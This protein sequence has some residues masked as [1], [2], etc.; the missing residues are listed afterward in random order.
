MRLVS[1]PKANASAGFHGG[2]PVKFV[3]LKLGEINPTSWSGQCSFIALAAILACVFQF[4]TYCDIV[5]FGGRA[6][7]GGPI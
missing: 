7:L 1:R 3:Q 5:Q 4:F 2:A 6:Q